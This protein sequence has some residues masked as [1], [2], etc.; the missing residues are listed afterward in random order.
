MTNVSQRGKNTH[1]NESIKI[2]EA[3]ELR[4]YMLNKNNKERG[5]FMEGVLQHVL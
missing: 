3:N 1:I 2:I 4:N 5:Y